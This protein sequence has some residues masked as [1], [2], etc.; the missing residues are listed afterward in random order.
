[1]TLSVNTLLV[2]HVLT[3]LRELPDESV[4]CIFTS[5]PYWNQRD[6]QTAPVPWPE[7]EFVPVEGLPPV[8]IP[9]ME[10]QLGLEP[11]YWQ[12]VGHLVLVFREC[13]RVLRKDGVMYV[14]IADRYSEGKKTVLKA[15]QLVGTSWMLAYAL[16]ADGWYFRD[17][18]VWFKPNPMPESVKSRTTKAHEYVFMFT[19]TES[20]WYDAESIKT[21]A[22][23][24]TA[25]MPDGWDT[26]KGAHSSIHR[27]GREK[28]SKTKRNDNEQIIGANKRSVWA[29]A[30]RPFSGAHFATFPPELPATCMKASCPPFVC[31]K[32]GTPFTRNFTRKLIP[33]AKASK[34]QVV[35]QRDLQADKNDQG[36][37]RTRDGHKHAHIYQT[38]TKGWDAQCSC[39][40]EPRPGIVLDPFMGSGTTAIV[41]HKLDRFFIGIENS[42]TYAETIYRP[43]LQQELGLLNPEP[44]DIELPGDCSPQKQAS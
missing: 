9:A 13:I 36:S 32:C 2:G 22:K 31:S 33:T 11:H 8:H 19:R 38:T 30:P 39:D 12:F 21:D 44:V 37:N 7:V 35:D 26:A 1:M 10:C 25:K 14:N 40:A 3:K 16:Q 23:S 17:D 20:Y 4:N 29:I 18:I 6:Y 27:K 41:A 5:P 34:K 24:E 15:K 43:R 28:G 42:K